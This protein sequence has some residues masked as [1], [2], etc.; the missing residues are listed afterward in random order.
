MEAVWVEGM[1]ESFEIISDIHTANWI[2]LITK[3]CISLTSKSLR[4]WR[5]GDCLWNGKMAPIIFCFYTNTHTLAWC[6]TRWGM[7][8]WTLP[9]DWRAFFYQCQFS[10]FLFNC[11]INIIYQCKNRNCILLDYSLD[12][13]QTTSLS[14][15]VCPLVWYMLLFNFIL[16]WNCLQKEGRNI[17]KIFFPFYKT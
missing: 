1:T 10:W 3:I 16:N 11:C 12:R 13:K 6:G 17:K 15:T 14:L 8:R 2:M 9:D 7:V 5:H 4:A